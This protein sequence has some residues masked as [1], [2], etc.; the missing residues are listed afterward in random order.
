MRNFDAKSNICSR[1]GGDGGGGGSK[2]RAR[3][4]TTSDAGSRFAVEIE[5][6]G[7]S[8]SL[9]RAR[10]D[11]SVGWAKVGNTWMICGVTAAARPQIPP[12]RA[13]HLTLLE[14]GLR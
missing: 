10:S 8:L 1:G 7:L 11:L 3:V 13:F 4:T 5:L 12:K 6:S 9:S 2:R 14:S